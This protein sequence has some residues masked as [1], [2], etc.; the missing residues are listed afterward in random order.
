MTLRPRLLLVAVSLVLVAAAC[1]GGSSTATDLA[2]PTT[3]IGTGGSTTTTT[4]AA[5]TAAGADAGGAPASP[6][7]ADS[8]TPEATATAP[9]GGQPL[10]GVPDVEVVRLSS[11][12]TVPLESLTSS[13][14]PTLLWFWAPH[15]V[16]CRREA[17]DLLA[18]AERHR[19]EIAVLGLG[20]QDSLDEAYDFLDDTGTGGL[21]MV[22]DRTG[23]SWVHFDVTNQ[24]TVVLLDG[25]GDVQGTW[26]RDFDEDAIVAAARA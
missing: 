25:D 13:G 17:P 9:A 20:A 23:R 1:G 18:F 22:W 16:F 6:G 7:P 26:F 2:A 3:T 19:G 15:C 10:V 11:G 24:P 5:P 21:T 14:T 12:A 8:A 4:A